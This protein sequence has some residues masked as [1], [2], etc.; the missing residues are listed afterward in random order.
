MSDTLAHTY[1]LHELFKRGRRLTIDEMARRLDCSRRTVMRVK[2]FMTDRLG[3]PIIVDHSR[4]YFS[5]DHR[6]ERYELPGI[7]LTAGELSAMATLALLVETLEPGLMRDSL[8]AAKRRIVNTLRAEGIDPDLLAE[9]VRVLVMHRR[10]FDSGNLITAADALVASRRLR[11]AYGASPSPP[12]E[13]SPQ[14]LVRY[15]DNWYLDAFCHTRR[16]LRTFALTRI[17][18]IEKLDRRVHRVG[19]RALREHFAQ[20]YGIFSGPATN[21]ATIH[22]TGPAARYASSEQWHPRQQ[23]RWI[24]DTTFELTFP[25]GDPRELTGDVMRWGPHAKVIK[26][27]NLRRKVAN[28]LRQ[29]ALQ[30]GDREESR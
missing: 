27:G 4:R 22:F 30:Y 24:T 11:I 2:K 5:Y 29:A 28:A 13:I 14:H 19:K 20:A 7:W 23:G 17:T 6:H 12:R 21:T 16:D 10:S 1:T 9:R 8:H 3:A 26:P 25:Y 15:R 18:E